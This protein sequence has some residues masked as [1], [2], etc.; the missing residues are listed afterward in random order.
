[1]SH[2]STHVMEFH[3]PPCGVMRYTQS[4]IAIL[5][6]I[7]S[8]H[9]STYSSGSLN[10]K[11]SVGREKMIRNSSPTRL[12]CLGPRASGL[13][14]LALRPLADVL[15]PAA[16]L[17][18]SSSPRPPGHCALRARLLGCFF[19]RAPNQSIRS[20]QTRARA[21]THGLPVRPNGAAQSRRGLSQGAGGCLGA[22]TIEC[23]LR[24]D[25]SDAGAVLRHRDLYPE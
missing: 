1:M 16:L 21:R 3:E 24:A 7:L 11:Y 20:V 13:S 12:Q 9:T 17:P 14:G 5:I 15:C 23:P 6:V 2:D 18:P 19:V 10:L 25:L 4:N 22:R 8:G